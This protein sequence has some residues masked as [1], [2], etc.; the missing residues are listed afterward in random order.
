MLIASSFLFIPGM[1]VLR[2]F[3]IVKSER[4]QYGK[5]RAGDEVAPAAVTPSMSQIPLPVSEIPLA[6]RAENGQA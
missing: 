4:K 3:G 2:Y 1:L 5:A 6:G